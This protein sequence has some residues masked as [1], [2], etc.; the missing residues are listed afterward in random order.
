MGR[1]LVPPDVDSIG[2]S[3]VQN[4]LQGESE[5]MPSVRVK[6]VTRYPAVDPVGYVH[7]RRSDSRIYRCVLR[8]RGRQMTMYMYRS[9]LLS[10]PALDDVL[11]WVYSSDRATTGYEDIGEWALDWEFYWDRERGVRMYHYLRS[12]VDAS[13]QVF[14]DEW[15]THI[16]RFKNKYAWA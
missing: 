6:Q 2:G 3:V 1:L 7:P 13:H 10:P 11:D 16:G 14:G 5:E 15:E 12:V 9:R 4:D 8:H